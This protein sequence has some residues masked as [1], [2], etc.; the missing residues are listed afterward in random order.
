MKKSIITS[1]LAWMLE[2][3]KNYAERHLVC[4]AYRGTTELSSV[5]NPPRN[6][7]GGNIWGS[8]TTSVITSTAVLGQNLWLYNTT[9]GSTE[10]ISN[11]YFIDGFYLGMKEGDLV[12]G[13]CA[14]GSSVSVYMGIIGVV[15]TAGC[16]LRSSGGVI[17]SS[18]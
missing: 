18:R 17:S 11:T 7:T 10:L 16:G 2:P 12:M 1:L 3:V 15:T 5:S 14:T 9:D 8:R 6:V 13:A 4:F